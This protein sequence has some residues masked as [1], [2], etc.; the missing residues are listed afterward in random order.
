M[1]HVIPDGCLLEDSAER[2]S[3]DRVSLRTL[4]GLGFS[5]GL[6]VLTSP[7]V[8]RASTGCTHL[9]EY[10]GRGSC[11]GKV[12]PSLANGSTELYRAELL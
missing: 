2:G 9:R 4:F 3:P 11:Q 1:G 10:V 8:G 6:T 5:T 12:H 7:L